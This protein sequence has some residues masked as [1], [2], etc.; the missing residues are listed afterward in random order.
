MK[1]EAHPMIS[2]RQS[3]MKTVSRFQKSPPS[4]MRAV[5]ENKKRELKN[6]RR[7]RRIK[8]LKMTPI[9]KFKKF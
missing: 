8:N 3:T 7:R 1:V 6:K 4:K 2:S 9:Q 5:L